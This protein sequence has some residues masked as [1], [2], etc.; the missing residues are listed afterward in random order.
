M[1]ADD[2]RKLYWTEPFT[3]FQLELKGGRELLVSRREH[4]TIGANGDRITVC[5]KIEEFEIIDL[6]DVTNVR[7]SGSAAENRTNGAA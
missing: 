7:V 1:T 6:A 4:M 2:V 3:P 5:P